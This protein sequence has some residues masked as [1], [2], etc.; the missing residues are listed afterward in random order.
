MT[1]A[2]LFWHRPATGVE[3]AAYEAELGDFHA[4]LAAEPPP[5]AA[6]WQRQLVLGP[7]REFCVA[8]PEPVDLGEEP[9]PVALVRRRVWP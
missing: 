4:A 1:L 7:A 5:G 3:A 6:V 9:A 2:Y 8:A